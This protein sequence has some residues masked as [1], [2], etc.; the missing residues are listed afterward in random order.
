M[1]WTGVSFDMEDCSG[2]IDQSVWEAM[3]LWLWTQWP[4]WHAGTASGLLKDHVHEIW[5][6]WRDL[7]SELQAS[8][9]ATLRVIRCFLSR[10]VF[11]PTFHL[12]FEKILPCARRGKHGLFSFSFYYQ[13]M[14]ISIQVQSY[15]NFKRLTAINKRKDYGSYN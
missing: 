6:L 15:P 10:G 13:E 2:E 14:S 12:L 9:G 11:H 3:T 1:L 4:V 7:P 8:S 5:L